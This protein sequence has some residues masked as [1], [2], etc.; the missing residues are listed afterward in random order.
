MKPSLT[1]LWTLLAGGLD[2]REKIIGPVVVHLLTGLI[3]FAVLAA[4]KNW[5]YPLILPNPGDPEYPIHASVEGFNRG[6]YEVAGE[7]YIA[8]LMSNWLAG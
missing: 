6:D 4:G 3:I 1:R 7:I 8:N 5:I 2:F